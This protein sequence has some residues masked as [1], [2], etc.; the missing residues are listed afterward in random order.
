M[1]LATGPAAATDVMVRWKQAFEKGLQ[2]DCQASL[3]ALKP[4]MQDKQFASANEAMR[5]ATYQLAAACSYQVKDNA[6]A[7]RYA[8]E[9]TRAGPA[10]ASL[11]HS[12]LGTEMEGNRLSDAVGTVEAMAAQN[13]EALN[14]FKIRWLYSLYRQLKDQPDTKLRMRF[15][16]VV[17]A[18]GY[19]PSEP[20]VTGDGFRR[21]RAVLLIEAGDKATATDLVRQISDPRILMDIVLDTRLRPL[22]ASDFDERSAVEK[23]LASIREVAASHANSLGPLLE[24]SRYQRM[25]GQVKEAL[26]T[27]ESARPDG[28]GGKDFIDL[29]ERKNWWWDEMAR[30]Y[31]MLGRY[32]DAVSAFDKAIA[33]QEDGNPNVSQTINLGHAHLRFGHPERALKTV[34]VFDASSHSASA[35]GKMEMRLVR[36]CAQAALRDQAALAENVR[37]AREHEKDHPEALVDLLLCA[38]DIEGAAAAMIR[39]LDDPDRRPDALKQLSNFDP[40]PSSYPQM[41]FETKMVVLRDRPDVQAAIRRAGGIMNFRLQAGEL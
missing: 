21:E 17:T 37:Y 32:D 28:P 1:L 27:L 3:A 31:Q 22:L 26:A 14:D 12:R 9:G 36:G 34:A 20:L 25:L 23:Q 41:P 18:P 5:A 11:W 29:D 7:Y 40:P 38:D 6:G 33:A 39:R 24:L 4:I 35:Y 19:Q 2:G 16:T 30:S 8:I 15:L 13:P 10:N